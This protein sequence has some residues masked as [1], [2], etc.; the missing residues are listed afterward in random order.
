MIPLCEKQHG[1][2]AGERWISP[3]RTTLVRAHPGVSSDANTK[4]SAYFNILII[5]FFQQLTSLCVFFHIIKQILKVPQLL[6]D[7]PV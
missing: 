7:G 6:C 4:N 2:D 3:A 5:L 1:L